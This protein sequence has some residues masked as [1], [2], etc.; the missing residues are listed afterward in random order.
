MVEETNCLKENSCDWRIISK[1]RTALMGIGTLLVLLI[2][3][4][5]FY[6]AEK[7]YF[8]KKIVNEGSIGVE[9]FLFLSGIGLFFSMQKDGNVLKFYCRR[10]RRIIP[11]YLSIAIPVYAILIFW[12]GSKSISDYLI[13][14]S[15]LG[16]WLLSGHFWYV[17]FILPLYLLYPIIF[18][19]FSKSHEKITLSFLL[20]LS[21]IIKIVLIIINVDYYNKIEVAVSRLPIFFIGCY[22]G[23][24]VYSKKSLNPKN[25]RKA[26]L[27]AFLLFL[28]IR[29][30]NIIFVSRQSVLNEAIIR[31]SNLGLT[32]LIIYTAIICLNFF[33]NHQQ[34]IFES[35]LNF[36]GK[37]SLEIYLVHEGMIYLYS[38]SPLNSLY[39]KFWFY[40]LVIVPVSILIVFAFAKL[41]KLVSNTLFA[42]KRN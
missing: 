21:F 11:I 33:S 26:F 1:Y 19:F 9:V 28:L 36:F 16:L 2:H 14:V 31:I 25:K 35:F 23:K 27:V 20:V 4:N 12:C 37:Y 8:L 42:T 32:F 30:L 6:W 24:L 7:L 17:S 15:T 10:Y 38:V 3:G 18:Y 39:P 40:Y 29:I 13:Q 41:L 22:C 34:L 5:E